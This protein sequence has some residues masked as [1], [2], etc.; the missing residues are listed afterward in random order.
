MISAVRENLRGRRQNPRST[1]TASSATVGLIADLPF[2]E[3]GG[4]LDRAR[5]LRS[6]STAR[7]VSVDSLTQAESPDISTEREL[8]SERLACESFSSVRS[9]L[10]AIRGRASANHQ[11]A[12]QMSLGPHHIAVTSRHVALDGRSGPWPL[13]DGSGPEHQVWWCAEPHHIAM[14]T[15]S[16][17][18]GA[19][20]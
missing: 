11:G 3:K 7:D 2:A 18:P 15:P 9:A 17:G 12:F 20:R 1:F 16:P 8:C 14:S 5:R 6:R 13:P 4:C 10:L 19:S